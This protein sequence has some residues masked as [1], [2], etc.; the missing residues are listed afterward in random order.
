MFGSKKVK[1]PLPKKMG[2][3]FPTKELSNILIN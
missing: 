1:D 3:F 2:R